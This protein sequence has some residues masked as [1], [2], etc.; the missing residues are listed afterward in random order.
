MGYSLNG[1]I[2]EISNVVEHANPH[3]TML[4]DFST[5]KAMHVDVFEKHKL[6]YKRLQEKGLTKLAIVQPEESYTCEQLKQIISLSGIHFQLFSHIS[7]AE[8]WL[9]TPKD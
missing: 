3:F 2:D 7:A 9:S 6:L 1:F 8:K 4:A 5:L